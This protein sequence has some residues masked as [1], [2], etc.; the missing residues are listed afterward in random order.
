M[1]LFQLVGCRINLGG[2]LGSVIVRDRFRPV[3]Y[4][5]YLVLQVIHGGEQHVHHVMSVGEDERDPEAEYKR[6]EELYGPMVVTVFPGAA[7]SLPLGSE[8]LVS[9]TEVLAGEAAASKAR[10]AARAKRVPSGRLAMALPDE[11]N[12]LPAMVS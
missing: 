3:T 1:A 9:E 10:A 7:R 2:D 5:E 12:A 11:V 6:L 4:P 8:T